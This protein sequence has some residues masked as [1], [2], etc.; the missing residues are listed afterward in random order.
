MLPNTKYEI[1]FD[2]TSGSQSWRQ[3]VR[4]VKSLGIQLPAGFSADAL[5]ANVQV[6]VLA[7]DAPVNAQETNAP[8]RWGFFRKF[9]GR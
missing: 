4:K 9:L 5:A 1:D 6:E 8:A 3:L 2:V 7:A